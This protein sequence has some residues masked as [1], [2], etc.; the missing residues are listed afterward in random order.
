MHLSQAQLWGF[1]VSLVL[2]CS[3]RMKTTGYLR[4]R[5]MNCED[6]RTLW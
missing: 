4:G 1:Y 3:E 6:N 2:K 5:R